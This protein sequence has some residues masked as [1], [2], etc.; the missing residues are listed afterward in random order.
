MFWFE[1]VF[2]TRRLFEQLCQAGLSYLLCGFKLKLSIREIISGLKGQSERVCD[3]GLSNRTDLK[4]S[5]KE[6]ATSCK[7]V[8]KYFQSKTAFLSENR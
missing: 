7:I 5:W 6:T 3:K 1:R 8:D 4:S 2:S